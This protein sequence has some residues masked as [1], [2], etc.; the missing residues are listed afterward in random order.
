MFGRSGAFFERFKAR[1]HVRAAQ[2]IAIK[3]YYICFQCK[4]VSGVPGP[5]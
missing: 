4:N 2:R 5:I 3:L 1:Q